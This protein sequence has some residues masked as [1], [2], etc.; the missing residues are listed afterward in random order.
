MF[1]RLAT[2]AILV[3]TVSNA[4]SMEISR[5]Q[6][7]LIRGHLIA[8]A[9][10]QKYYAEALVQSQ[11][12]AMDLVSLKFELK[13]I[14]GE[15]GAQIIADRLQKDIDA[16]SAASSSSSSVKSFVAEGIMAFGDVCGPP[17]K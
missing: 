4:H 10:A 3:G 7:E 14:S 8:S 12:V 11:I 17:P 13:H 6:C 1:R 15:A 16:I 2:T 9:T 5:E